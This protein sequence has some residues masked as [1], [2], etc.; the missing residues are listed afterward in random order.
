MCG[1]F[2]VALPPGAGSEA[3]AIA[4]TGLFALQHRGQESAGI[5]ISDRSEIFLYKDLGMIAQVLDDRRL[6]AMKS[7]LAMAHCRYS[8]TGSTVWENAQPTFRLGPRRSVAVGHNGNLVNAVMLRKQ[9]EAAGAIFQSGADTEVLLHLYARSRAPNPVEAVVQLRK[10]F[11][12]EHRQLGQFVFADMPIDVLRQLLHLEL[13]AETLAEE[14]HVVADDRTNVEQR[15]LRMRA[16]RRQE[17]L[18]RFGGMGR[19]LGSAAV[20]FRIIL[21]PPG[22]QIG[23]RH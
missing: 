15:R 12:E 18:Q 19:R 9:L 14:C 11:A 4:A 7:D 23:D 17:L 6:P 22:K 1:V 10:T 13:A 20:C 2:G 21:A 16:E 3:A 8:T 5:A